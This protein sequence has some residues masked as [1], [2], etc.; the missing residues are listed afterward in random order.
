MAFV[1]LALQNPVANRGGR[2]ELD[3]APGTWSS[4]LR[5]KFV[6]RSQPR[7]LQCASSARRVRSH[8]WFR[9]HPCH[10]LSGHSPFADRPT[11]GRTPGELVRSAHLE[12]PTNG[13]TIVLATFG[14]PLTVRAGRPGGVRPQADACG[15]RGDDGHDHGTKW[16]RNGPRREWPPHRVVGSEEHARTVSPM[17]LLLTDSSTCP[18]E[19][20]SKVGRRLSVGRWSA[21]SPRNRVA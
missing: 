1:T 20:G 17:T 7:Q 19:A 16:D 6:E 11:F 4:P 18:G 10:G 3:Q 9:F 5:S 12:C 14:L 2:A 8:W 13:S 21:D 15:D